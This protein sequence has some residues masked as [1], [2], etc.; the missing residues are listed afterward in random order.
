MKISTGDFPSDSLEEHLGYLS[1]L[2]TK[3]NAVVLLDEADVFLQR[4]TLHNPV[5]NAHVSS[6]F[7]EQFMETIVIPRLT[8]YLA[9]LRI[10]EY[11]EHI[12][13]LT[14]NRIEVIDDAVKSRIHVP[15][16]YYPLSADARRQLWEDM[17]IRANW[18]R[19]P[20]WLDKKTMDGVV[21]KKLN[22]REIKNIARIGHAQ[23]RNAKRDLEIDDLMNGLEAWEQFETDFKQLNV[24]GEE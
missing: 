22:G 11:C 24:K 1:T 7:L 18:G 23:A 13:F 5:A 19:R 9:L 4:R 3:W 8:R 14:T 21:E 15:I 17:I 2:A 6:K 20:E 16:A 12:V 10:L